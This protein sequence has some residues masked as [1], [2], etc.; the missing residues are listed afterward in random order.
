MKKDGVIF[1]QKVSESSTPELKS[2]IYQTKGAPKRGPHQEE[3]RRKTDQ[4][5]LLLHGSYPR[6]LYARKATTKSTIF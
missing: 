4:P 3:S 2:K 6:L 5:I 1:N